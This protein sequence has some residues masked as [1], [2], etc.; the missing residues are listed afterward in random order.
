MRVLVAGVGNVLRSDDAF[1]VEVARRLVGR[2]VPDGVKVV[3]TGIA[4]VALVH[5]LQEGWDA[6]IVLD[7]VGRDKPP[8]TVMLIELEVG[9]VNDMSWSQR[10]DFL[11]DMHLA[12]PERALMLARALGALP[13]VVMMVGC[14]PV[15]ADTFAQGMSA[16]VTA[17]VDVAVEVVHT[18]LARFADLDAVPPV[19]AVEAGER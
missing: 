15:D 1:G 3:E 11:A 9:D 4:G 5:E 2:P 13:P 7:A 17:A 12:T 8:G 18:Q 16:P 14:Q 6:V 19:E 10:S